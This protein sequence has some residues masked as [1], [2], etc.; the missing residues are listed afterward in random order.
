MATALDNNPPDQPDVVINEV[1]CFIQRKSEVLAT[2]DLTKICADYYSVD[3]IEKARATLSKCV[4]NK[5][6]VPKQ[7]GTEYEIRS[8]TVSLMIKLCLDP[9]ITLPAF[10]AR[11]ISNLPPVD[12]THVD[13][14]AVLSEL[15]ALRREVRA[16][17][18]LREEVNTL[19]A[20][21]HSER[22][23]RNTDMSDLMLVPATEEPVRQQVDTF[24]DKANQ[25]I[26]DDTAF[27][28]VVRRRRTQSSK[29]VVGKSES[30]NHVQS[31]AT[32]RSVDVFISRLHPAT[33]DEELINCVNAC[34]G[35]ENSINVIEVVCNRLKSKYESLYASYHVEIRVDSAL[36]KQAVDVF[37]SAEVWPSGVFVKRFFRKRNGSPQ[38]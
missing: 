30:N 3:D 28:N 8:R 14:S 36:L 33:T 22:R 12:A 13:M 21:L 5:K 37:M 34:T 38:Q 15:S 4:D 10:C 1:L 23:E 16:M 17:M 29:L 24:A 20:M 6:R 32:T 19:K 31:V 27:K 7:K 9:S 26:G 18:D 2:D 35:T 25:L 11:D